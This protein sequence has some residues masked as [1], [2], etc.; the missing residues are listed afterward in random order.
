[1][2]DDKDSKGVE[3][4]DSKAISDT[5][6]SNVDSPKQLEKAPWW[7]IFWDNDPNREVGERKFLHKLDMY[8]LTILS[9]GYFIKNL[10]Q[11]NIA[12]AYVSG[13]KEDLKMNGNEVNLIDVAWTVIAIRFLVGLAES[14]F[15]PAAHF[16]IGSWYK[17]SELGK[18][19]CIFHASSAAA[20][21]FSGYLQAAVYKGLNGV[22]GK[23]GWQWLFIM[24]GVISIP[25]C[26]LGFFL[27]P[28]LPENS[29][30][31]YLTKDHRELA[32]TRMET[33]GRAPRKK[34][35]WSIIKRVFT[36]WHVYALS[37]LYI[38][39][40]NSSYSSSVNPFSLW[41][42]SKKYS[43]SLINIIPTG[44]SAVQ[45]VTTVSFAIVSD[46]FRNRAAVMSFAACFGLFS[47]LVLAIWNI[48]VGLKW[49]AFFIPRAGVVYGPLAMSWANEICS[50]DAEERAMVLG[51]MNAGGYAFNAWLPLL[52]F[53]ARDSPRFRKGFIWST[54]AYSAQIGMVGIVAWLWRWEKTKSKIV[55]EEEPA[56]R[57]VAD[58]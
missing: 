36:R 58:I 30:A 7:A 35:G 42:K 33:I 44:Q 56:I 23:A 48:P 55:V 16:L 12:N 9:L 53:P 20:G 13:M 19:A 14:I 22:H 25:I 50:G 4:R 38:I 45:L 54:C 17:P 8:L 26:L 32:K 10:D 47:A 29:R 31:F 27:I 6:S 37:V 51:I 15:Y 39:F 24:D 57:D 21:M 46:Y 49:F 18:R 41:L 34:L 52:T 2:S 43:V 1:M 40:I 5:D 3:V 28:D 11:T